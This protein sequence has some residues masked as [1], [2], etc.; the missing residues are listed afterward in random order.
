MDRSGS[1]GIGVDR[2]DRRGSEW[3]GADRRVSEWIGVY[4]RDRSVSERSE[5]IGVIGGYRSDRSES[6]G[7][8][9]VIGGGRSDVT[10]LHVGGSFAPNSVSL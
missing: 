2:R 3:I 6:E 10:S 1:A 8:R 9:R 4:R 7:D 5:W